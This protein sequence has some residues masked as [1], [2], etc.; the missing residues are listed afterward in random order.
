M[1]NR[2]TLL[3]FIFFGITAVLQTAHADDNI[4]DK[5]INEQ[6]VDKIAVYGNAQTNKMVRDKTV[7]GEEAKRIATKGTGNAWDA[8]AQSITTGKIKAG[9]QIICVVFLKAVDTANNAPA[10]VMLRLQESAAPYAEIKSEEM[11]IS[12]DWNQYQITTVVNKD[13]AGGEA[14][15]VVQMNYGAQTIDVGPVFILNMNKTTKGSR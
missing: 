7:L 5:A 8:A 12:K 3:A 2:T 9:D 13:Y 4:A 11:P 10:K 14:A 6:R 1:K 15:F